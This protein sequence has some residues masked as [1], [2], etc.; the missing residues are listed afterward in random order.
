MYYLYYK[1]PY[2]VKE[3]LTK[4]RTHQTYRLKSVAICEEREPLQEY[5][6]ELP[7]NRQHLY[8]IESNKPPN[9]GVRMDGDTNDQP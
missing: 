3:A 6:D 4:N 1:E 5:I 9:C 8:V 7:K 2:I